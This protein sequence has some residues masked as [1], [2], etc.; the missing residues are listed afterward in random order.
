MTVYDVAII[1]GGPSGLAAAAYTAGFQLTPILI[2]PMLGGKASYEF[3]LNGQYYPTPIWGLETVRLFEKHVQSQMIAHQT[4]EVHKVRKAENGNFIVELESQ[5][6]EARAVI[7]ATGAKPQRLYVPGEQE[8]WGR[9][10]SFS[11]L[12]HAPLFRGREVVVI[13]NGERTQVAILKLATI[14]N[15]V[16]WLSTTTHEATAA[17][18]REFEDHPKV[19]PLFGWELQRILG[20]DCV[21]AIEIA[22]DFTTREVTVDGVFVELGLIPNVE[23][24]RGML[25]FNPET[26]HIPV[27]QHCAT[28]VPGLFAAGD[29]TDVYAEQITVAIGEGVKAAISTWDYLVTLPTLDH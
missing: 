25:P 21:T 5:Q 12:S 7:V 16:Y 14:A 20:N 23:F 28:T 13:G 2:A 9:G 15:H 1:G 4:E 8:F 27:N 19:T 11:A 26:G 17:R 18:L 6:I 22:T 29:V 3:K 10:V 24:L